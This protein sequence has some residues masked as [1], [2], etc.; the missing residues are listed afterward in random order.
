VDVW[1]DYGGSIYA[2]TMCTMALLTPWRYPRGA[3]LGA[4]PPASYATA[5][6]A[7]KE[8]AGSPYERVRVA[9][10]RALSRCPG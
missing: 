7:L 8:A 2:T 4:K 6:A 10:Q 3:G 9:A 5:I 1:A